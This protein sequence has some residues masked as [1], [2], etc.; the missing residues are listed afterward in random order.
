MRQE[1]NEL[2]RYHQVSEKV[3]EI[4]ASGD[5]SGFIIRKLQLH[6]P[7]DQ[8]IEQLGG[9]SPAAES[10]QSGHSPQAR[11]QSTLTDRTDSI[12]SINTAGQVKMEHASHVMDETGI[13]F[14]KSINTAGQVKMEHASHVME[15]TGI[16]F[17]KHGSRWTEVPLGDIFIEHL[18]LL[19]FCWEYPIFSSLSKRHFA[20]DFNAGRGTCCS[21]LL[22][23]GILAVGCRFS[24]HIEARMDPEDSD[25]AGMH[26]YL[27]AERLLSLCRA[28]RS[29]T[30]VQSMYLM[31]TWNASRGDYK[32]A[33]YYSGQA[34]RMA[35]EM[36]LHQ[37]GEPGDIPDD[38][39]E[40][41]N[42]TF[43]GS[44]MLDQYVDRPSAYTN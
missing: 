15:G 4:L 11:R 2:R 23:N 26:C 32:K 22:V 44:F 14:F 8:I 20:E 12:N 29:V 25:T 16:Y 42:T 35:V 9:C 10:T 40:V 27:E 1:I 37:D 5:Q 3:L 24:D 6:E 7:L 17:F 30:V 41:R 31:S 19:Y 39:R 34:I 13:Y 28:E 43:W 18:L 38:M 33:R 36:G 21:S